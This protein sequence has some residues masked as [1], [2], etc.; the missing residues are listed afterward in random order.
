MIQGLY[1][2]WYII[3]ATLM[4]TIGVPD[5][6]SFSNGLFLIFYALYVLDLIYQGRKRTRLSDQ[7]VIWMKP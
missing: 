2:A 3:G 7:S 4:L 5:V 6:L 1:W